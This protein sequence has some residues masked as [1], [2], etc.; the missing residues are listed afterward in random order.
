MN[1]ENFIER[2]QAVHGGT[3]NYAK[4]VYINAYKKVCIICPKHGE[5]WQS[6]HHHLNGHGCPVCNESHLENDIRLMLQNLNIT[7]IQSYRAQWLGRQHLDFFLPDLNIGIECQGEQHFH[8]VFYRSSKWTKEKRENNFR[9]IKELDKL[10]K[11]KCEEHGVSLFYY[12]T[13]PKDEW[14]YECYDNTDIIVE[15]LQKRLFKEKFN[16]LKKKKDE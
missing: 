12:T 9:K 5:F 3:Y 11:D 4:V 8:E 16:E 1:T 14:L 10:K 13:L 6:P 15:K 7:F 2:A